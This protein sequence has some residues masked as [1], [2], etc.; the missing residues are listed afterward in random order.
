MTDSYNRPLITE[1]AIDAQGRHR[2]SWALNPDL[3]DAKGPTLPVTSNGLISFLERLSPLEPAEFGSL[4]QLLSLN[5]TKGLQ[6]LTWQLP[7]FASKSS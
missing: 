6:R 1:E 4:T 7:K 3:T 5:Y 2:Q